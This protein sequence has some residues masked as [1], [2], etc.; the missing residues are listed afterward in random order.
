[1]HWMYAGT[2]VAKSKLLAGTLTLILLILD[3][4]LAF[5]LK[6]FGGKTNLLVMMEFSENKLI[7]LKELPGVAR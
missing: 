7:K 6:F 3:S 2:Q 4:L 5:L 1:M